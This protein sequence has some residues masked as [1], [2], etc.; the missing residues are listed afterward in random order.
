L[1]GENS[2]AGGSSASGRPP[3]L[4]WAKGNGQI[5]SWASPANTRSARPRDRAIQSSPSLPTVTPRIAPRIGDFACRN[6]GVA[7]VSTSGAVGRPAAGG[8]GPDRTLTAA[9]E[10]D[11][12]HGSDDNGAGFHTPRFGAVQR[13]EKQVFASSKREHGC[14]RTCRRTEFPLPRHDR[15]DRL[16]ADAGRGAGPS[17]PTR[18]QTNASV[19]FATSLL[20]H[21]CTRALWRTQVSDVHP[22]PNTDK[23]GAALPESGVKTHQMWQ[24]C[25]LQAVRETALRQIGGLITAT[26]ARASRPRRVWRRSRARR[27]N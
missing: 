1:R 24:R 4:R 8:H 11:P 7:E 18:P 16:P 19:R 17:S 22:A 3:V 9:G 20:K 5:Q 6:A 12:R 10:G 23:R 15:H 25:V 2:L 26:A 14:R 13:R 21:R 27:R